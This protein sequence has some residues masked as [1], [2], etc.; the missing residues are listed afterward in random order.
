[1]S[2]KVMCKLNQVKSYV[3]FIDSLVLLKNM[4]SE[5]KM[6]SK[7]KLTREKINSAFIELKKINPRFKLSIEVKINLL[8]III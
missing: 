5:K 6:T 2:G 1:M 4:V 3:L 8:F 7:F